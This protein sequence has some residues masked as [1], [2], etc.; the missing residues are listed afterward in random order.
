MNSDQSIYVA[1]H[2]GMVG[3]AVVRLLQQRGFQ[4]II[5]RD[6]RELDLT[7]QMAVQQ[8]RCGDGIDFEL[9]GS[10][11]IG[12][13]RKLQRR[14]RGIGWLLFRR[15]IQRQGTTGFRQEI[16]EPLRHFFIERRQN[17]QQI[18]LAPLF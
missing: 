9:E 4:R 10:R 13:Q 12:L 6:R 8:F 15:V 11:Q 7:D 1:G 17:G 2:K 5:I 18:R 14:H 16:E 3:S